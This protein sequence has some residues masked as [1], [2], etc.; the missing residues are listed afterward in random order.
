MGT[1]YTK[2]YLL[3]DISFYK[4]KFPEELTMHFCEAKYR[5]LQFLC[6]LH[7]TLTFKICQLRGNNVCAIALQLLRTAKKRIKV[8]CKGKVKQ[9]KVEY[10]S[11]AKTGQSKWWTIRSHARIQSSHSPELQT[12]S[13]KGNKV[14]L[15]LAQTQF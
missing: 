7:F 13:H 4:E 6:I 11:A 3:C 1:V 14:L 12:E 15:S 2:I 9:G 8:N 10:P 5:T